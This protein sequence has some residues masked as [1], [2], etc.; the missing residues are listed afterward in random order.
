M[1][2][3]C[4]I[5]DERFIAVRDKISAIGWGLAPEGELEQLELA[6][7]LVLGE[8]MDHRAHCL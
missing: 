1:C 6:N 3:E 7:L 4:E 5:L 8:I 2:E